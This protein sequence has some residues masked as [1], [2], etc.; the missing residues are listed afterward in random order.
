LFLCYIIILNI[1]FSFFWLNFSRFCNFNPS[2]ILFFILWLNR[3]L[4]LLRL[5]RFYFRFWFWCW[6]LFSWSCWNSDRILFHFKCKSWNM[7]ILWL[8]FLISFLLFF[9]WHSNCLP[10]FV[11]IFFFFLNLLLRFFNLGSFLNLDL[12]FRCFF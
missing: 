1:S 12:R 2:I 6:C 7:C 10:S 9:I 8:Y 3:L 5:C 4:L 11:F